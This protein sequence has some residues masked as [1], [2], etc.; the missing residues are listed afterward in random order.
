MISFL[1][2]LLTIACGAVE[3]ERLPSLPTPNG[4]FVC[5]VLGEDILLAGGTHW[6]GGVKNGLD[7]VHVFATSTKTWRP[8]GKL[9]TPQAYAVSGVLAGHDERLQIHILGG[10]TGSRLVS[11][12]RVLMDSGYVSSHPTAAAVAV[13]AAGGILDRWLVQVGGTDDPANLAGLRRTALAMN[14]DDGR[15]ES[16]PDYPG[17]PFGTAAS[18]ASGSELF[19]F[20]GANW[21]TQTKAVRN[22]DEAYAFDGKTR[23][24]RRLAHLPFPVRGI[25]AVPLA[26]GLLYLAGG[27]KEEGF[28]AEAWFYDI[29]RDEYDAAPALPYPGM[30]ALLLCDHFLY[31]L[32]GEHQQRARTDAFFRTP[33]SEFRGTR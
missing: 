4:G 8:A 5:A 10:T 27:Y 14:L 20:G 23:T 1:T 32:G 7:A 28:T 19:V 13:L 16:L 25:V 26:E 33:L 22:S 29:A 6:Q 17:A 15:I 18:A 24:W 12:A 2:Y 21:D 9:P 30:V 11:D 31:C 3:W